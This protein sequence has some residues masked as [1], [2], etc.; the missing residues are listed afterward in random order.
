MLS[1]EKKWWFENNVG[2]RAQNEFYMITQYRADGNYKFGNCNLRLDVNSW[3][4]WQEQLKH[5][6]D[7]PQIESADQKDNVQIN[8]FQGK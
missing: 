7:L 8:I 5:G 2:K 3:P 1:L 4:V 6:I